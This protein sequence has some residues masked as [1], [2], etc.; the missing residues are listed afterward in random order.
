MQ[1]ATMAQIVS[2]SPSSERLGSFHG[3][4]SS[5]LAALLMADTL[6]STASFRMRCG[7]GP[8]KRH[9]HGPW[10]PGKDLMRTYR[11]PRPNNGRLGALI[12]AVTVSGAAW[13][14]I[15]VFE[16][17]DFRLR[18]FVALTSFAAFVST[19]ASFFPAWCDPWLSPMVAIRNDPA[20]SRGTRDA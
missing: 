9:A 14:L 11:R 1:L 2:G 8:S 19:G 7:E 5:A 15:R 18:P 13:M 6:E 4:V 20:L 3:G 12:G 10:E 17:R 16:I